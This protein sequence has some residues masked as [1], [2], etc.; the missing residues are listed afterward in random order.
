[1]TPM[2]PLQGLLKDK[3]KSTAPKTLKSDILYNF[4]NTIVKLNSWIV[5]HSKTKAKTIKIT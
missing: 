5:G 1:M 3:M 4:E 2:G